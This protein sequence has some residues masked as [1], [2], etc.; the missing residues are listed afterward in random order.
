MQWARAKF[1]GARAHDFVQRYAT[2]HGWKLISQS[3]TPHGPNW[4]PERKVWDHVIVYEDE[5]GVQYRANV[6]VSVFGEVHLANET[7]VIR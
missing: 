4:L 2:A 7:I 3:I 1:D 6:K 5:K